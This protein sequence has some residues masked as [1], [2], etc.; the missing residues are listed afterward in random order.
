MGT[1]EAETTSAWRN[2]PDEYPPL[3]KSHDALQCTACGFRRMV[4]IDLGHSCPR[5]A[6]PKRKALALSL[7]AAGPKSVR[8]AFHRALAEQGIGREAILIARL[9]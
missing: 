9:P 7:S 5:L 2:H 6:R 4:P 1:T 8:R 3:I